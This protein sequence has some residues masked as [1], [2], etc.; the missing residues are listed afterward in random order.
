MINI[1]AS[2]LS[3]ATRT[4]GRGISNRVEQDGFS[5]P[6]HE[7]RKRD[8]LRLLRQAERRYGREPGAFM[9]WHK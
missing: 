8:E 4:K 6:E 9:R 7:R 2:T 3:I 1:L 5:L